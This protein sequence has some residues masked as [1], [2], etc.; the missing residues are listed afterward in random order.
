LVTSAR[1][2][3][4]NFGPCNTDQVQKFLLPSNHP[5]EKFSQLPLEKYAVT[6]IKTPK[7]DS[8]NQSTNKT[9]EDDGDYEDGN[10]DNE[11]EGDETSDYKSQ[12]KKPGHGKNVEEE[13]DLDEL[14]EREEEEDDENDNDDDS[15]NKLHRS[16]NNEDDEQDEIMELRDV[17]ELMS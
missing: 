3:V 11:G 4:T 8:G 15:V 12:S 5:G 2:S 10:M 7:L 6:A 16:R 1:T 14:N 17:D 9:V 13:E